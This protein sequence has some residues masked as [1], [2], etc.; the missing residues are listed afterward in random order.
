MIKL[1]SSCNPNTIEILGCKPE[2]YLYVN[3]IGKQLLDNADM[4]VSQLCI[5]TFA[6]YANSQLRRLENKAARSLSQPEQESNMLKS[7]ENA[8][9]SFKH[10]YHEM[11][12]YAIKLYLDDAVERDAPSVLEKEIFMDVS[13]SHYPLRDYASIH[14]EMRQIIASYEK[15]GKRN[16]NAV[17]HDKLNKHMTHLI[18]LFLTCLDLLETGSII[19][20]REKDMPLL[21]SILNGDY[22]GEDKQPIPEFFDLVSDFEKKLDYAKRNTSIQVKPDTKR[23]NEFRMYVN[24]YIVRNR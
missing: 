22:L 8:S 21:R 5:H 1:L 24:E 18:R 13:L 6:G 23:I 4:F 17:T 10:R 11:S 3:D 14:S 15:F 19:T 9:Y 12:D 2:H 7:I 16:Q 20:Y